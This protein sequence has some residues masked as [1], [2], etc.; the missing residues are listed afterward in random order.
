MQPCCLGPSSPPLYHGSI[1]ILTFDSI[2]Q[3]LESL[4]NDLF[5]NLPFFSLV[6]DFL[7]LFL[8]KINYGYKN[9]ASRREN[10]QY[11]ETENLSIGVLWGTGAS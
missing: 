8:F 6:S 10:T 3:A 4:F 2:Y 9:K 5:Q 11:P 1:F 7:S